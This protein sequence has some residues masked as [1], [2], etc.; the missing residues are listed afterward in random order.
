MEGCRPA[1]ND[2]LPRLAALA[3][4]AIAELTPMK[5]GDVWADRDAPA[6]PSTR[7]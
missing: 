5:G 6:R 7:A 1:T 2:D 4:L 3:Q